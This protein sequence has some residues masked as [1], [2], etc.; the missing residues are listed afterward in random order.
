MSLRESKEVV[1]RLL[2]GQQVTVAFSSREAAARFV[3]EAANVGALCE[4]R[5]SEKSKSGAYPSE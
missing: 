4:P 1:D 3:V 5:E 2:D